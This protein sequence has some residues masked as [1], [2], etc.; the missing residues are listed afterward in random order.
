MRKIKYSWLSLLVTFALS[1][2]AFAQTIDKP[3]A[4]PSIDAI[5]AVGVNDAGDSMLG[6]LAHNINHYNTK[7][8]WLFGTLV[9]ATNKEDAIKEGNENIKQFS[10]VEGPQKIPDNT[11]NTW[12]CI[13]TSSDPNI[14]GLT[15]T[16]VPPNNWIA[17][18]SRFKK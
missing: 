12:A 2:S 14:F 9:S 7:D 18:F 15:I 13:Y 1:Q 8:K 17:Q 3:E 5:K 6:W 4:C 16:P 10:G 11:D